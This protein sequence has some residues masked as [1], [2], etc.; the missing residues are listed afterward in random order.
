MLLIYQTGSASGIGPCFIFVL[1]AAYVSQNLWSY[2]SNTFSYRNNLG[3][4]IPAGIGSA[5]CVAAANAILA[6]S[7]P[8]IA[9]LTDVYE[10]YV[11]GTLTAT[12]NGTA[13][14][15][16]V[17]AGD[18]VDFRI[19]LPAI[20]T[21]PATFATTLTF[22]DPRDNADALRGSVTSSCS[23]DTTYAIPSTTGAT[24]AVALNAFVNSTCTYTLNVGGR[25]QI[26]SQTQA[27][28]VTLHRLDVD[29][30]TITREDGS[31]YTAAGTYSLNFGGVQVAGPFNTGTGIDVLPGTYQFSLNYTD[32]DGAKTQTQTLT[33]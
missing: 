23:G 28:A 15:L 17:N 9:P 6:T 12:V 19:N 16:T 5:G 1:Q 4:C 14:T 10:V 11:P 31:T 13:Q 32:F 3:T 18:E 22:A 30:V 21:V 7:T 2:P 25:S 33:F 26:L 29:A 24:A 20:G 27:N 8:G